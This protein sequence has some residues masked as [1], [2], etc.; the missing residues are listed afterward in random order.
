MGVLLINRCWLGKIPGPLAV[1][2]QGRGRLRTF[3]QIFLYFPRPIYHFFVLL[4]DFVM[5]RYRRLISFRDSRY[6][7]NGE[8]MH[9]HRPMTAHRPDID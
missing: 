4:C 5:T 6:K 9:K 1:F 7:V 2:Q 8:S 3:L